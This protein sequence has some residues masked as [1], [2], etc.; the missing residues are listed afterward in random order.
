ME[1]DESRWYEAIRGGDAGFDGVF[2]AGVVTT[3]WRPWRAY[4]AMYLWTNGAGKA[5]KAT[6]TKTTKTKMK[7][8]R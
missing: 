4:A 3:E 1:R 5:T 7:E 2:F 6:E 8:S